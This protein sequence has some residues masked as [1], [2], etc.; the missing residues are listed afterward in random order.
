MHIP[1]TGGVTF[2]TLLQY[3]YNLNE[4]DLRLAIHEPY[5]HLVNQFGEYKFVTF[6]RDPIARV[7]SE[8]NYIN[9]FPDKVPL[10]KAHRLP[11]EGNPIDT[12]S[13]EMCK[14]LSRLDPQDPHISIEDHLK[15][16][17]EVLEKDFFFI[18]ITEKLDESIAM[19]YSRLGWEIPDKIPVMNKTRSGTKKFPQEILDRVAQRNQAD[20]KLYNFALELFEKQKKVPCI[21]KKP[22]VPTVFS[23]AF[24]FS[25]DQPVDGYGWSEL[26]EVNGMKFRWIFTGYNKAAINFSL[27]PEFS[28][29]FR[30]KALIQ[31]KFI[32]QLYLFVN[33]KEVNVTYKLKHVDK[34]SLDFVL[35]R[36]SAK[37]PKKLL[38]AKEKTSFIFKMTPPKNPYLF[39]LYNRDKGIIDNERE[40]NSKAALIKIDI[41][42]MK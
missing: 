32:K 25:F 17:M 24:N 31:P 26:F 12:A 38:S 40:L 36:G 15:S 37:I 35:V 16:A 2:F 21:N 11:E 19:F 13:N 18:G 23:T 41:R 1:K 20:I 30:F 33:E 4:K 5:H 28:Y 42:K 7:V 6:L 29:V 14:M 8:E 9:S 10:K 3:Q 27:D 39:S 34:Q 22:N